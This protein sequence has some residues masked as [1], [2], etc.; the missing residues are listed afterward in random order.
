MPKP[1]LTKRC[2][3]CGKWMVKRFKRPLRDTVITPYESP[4]YWGCFGCP[5]EEHF[6]S[7]EEAARSEWEH[8]NGI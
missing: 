7:E 5:H 6:H 3:D 1:N 2:P 8:L 4:W